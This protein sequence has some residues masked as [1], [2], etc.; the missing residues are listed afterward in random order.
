MRIWYTVQTLQL[1]GLENFCILDYRREFTAQTKADKADLRQKTNWSVFPPVF[2]EAKMWSVFGKQKL[3]LTV[4][5]ENGE[6]KWDHHLIFPA[7]KRK[8]SKTNSTTETLSLR[9]RE[10]ATS[11][12]AFILHTLCVTFYEYLTFPKPCGSYRC[13]TGI[14]TLHSQPLNSSAS[15]NS[16][17]VDRSSSLLVP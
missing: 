14:P 13:G 16:S 17:S 2:S 1:S 12:E 10:W 6:L 3:C 11:H 9:G 7:A 4:Q 5:K 15:S 8:E